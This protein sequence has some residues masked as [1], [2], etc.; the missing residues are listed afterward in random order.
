MLVGEIKQ[1]TK[2]RFKSMDDFE[3]Y[4]N[5]IDNSGYDSEDVTSTRYIY[6]LNTPEF[7]NAKRSH[8][9]KAQ[10]LKKVSLNTPVTNVVFPR[11]VIVL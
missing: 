4:I 1:K 9:V 2:I 7:I 6:K 10:M 3:S 5:A 8:M 11:V